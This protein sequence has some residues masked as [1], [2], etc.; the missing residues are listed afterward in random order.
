MSMTG[1]EMVDDV[2][3]FIRLDLMMDIP[4]VGY[5]LLQELMDLN[6]KAFYAYIPSNNYCVKYAIP[7]EL[8]LK[9]W[10]D[11]VAAMDPEAVEYLG[12]KALE[13][14]PSQV[15][16]AFKQLSPDESIK[17]MSEQVVYFDKESGKMV[18]AQLLH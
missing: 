10:F 8:N 4:I 11:K 2:R 18:A 14:S 12:E 3:N 7:F 16:Y 1:T 15:T 5:G 13:W 6:N 17:E 9:T